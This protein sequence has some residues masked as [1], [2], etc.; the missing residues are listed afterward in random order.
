MAGDH[1]ASETSETGGAEA[2]LDRAV[3]QRQ[4]VAIFGAVVWPQLLSVE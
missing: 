1:Q 2:A 4:V 3:A